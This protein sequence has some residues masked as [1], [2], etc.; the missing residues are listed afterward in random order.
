[1]ERIRTLNTIGR[2]VFLYKGNWIQK[3]KKSIE[4]ME[5]IKNVIAVTTP[6]NSTFSIKE[7]ATEMLRSKLTKKA[8]ITK[9]ASF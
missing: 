3:S 2:T 4:K 1:M 6:F 7:T 8:S 5:R 9:F